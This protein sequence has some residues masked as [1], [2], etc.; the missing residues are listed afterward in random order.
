MKFHDDDDDDDTILYIYN[1]N[2]KFLSFISREKTNKLVISYI[3]K[4]AGFHKTS[5]RALPL[6]ISQ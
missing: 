6:I 1:S 3:K 5:Q 4:F 2:Y